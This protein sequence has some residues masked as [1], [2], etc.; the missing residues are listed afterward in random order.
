[1]GRAKIAYQ[2]KNLNKCY[3]CYP[4]TDRQIC[5]PY[6]LKLEPSR[7]DSASKLTAEITKTLKVY[8]PN[9]NPEFEDHI[10]KYIYQYLSGESDSDNNYS[11]VP[12]VV[13][14]C[15]KDNE[16]MGWTITLSDATQ[17][18]KHY[19]LAYFDLEL[20]FKRNYMFKNTY[21]IAYL[22]VRYLREFQMNTPDK[23]YE[24]YH[25]AYPNSDVYQMMIDGAEKIEK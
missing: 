18:D 1:M 16:F 9:F 7:E 2:N 20:K 23:L 5:E 11:R 21:V 14:F 4:S 17:S 13:N 24:D 25:E 22:S 10:K 3:F 8:L 12:G 15:Y 6:S 19:N